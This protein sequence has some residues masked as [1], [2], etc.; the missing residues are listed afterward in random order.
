M[1]IYGAP[2][3]YGSSK[4]YGEDYSGLKFVLDVDWM[5]TGGFT[6]ESES[7]NIKALSVERGRKYL[8][9]ADGK[10]FAVAETGKLD[11]KL[12]NRTGKYDP[13]KTT[14]VLYPYVV[15]RRLFQLRAMFGYDEYF[16]ICGQTTNIQP[17]GGLSQEARLTGSDGWD[18]LRTAVTV[19][20]QEGQGSEVVIGVLLDAVGW[21]WGRDIG[22]GAST[23]TYWWCDQ[24]SANSALH[25]LAHAELGRL[26]IDNAG[27][28]TF[29][30]RHIIPAVT[31]TIRSSDIDKEAGYST[32]QPWDVVRNRVTIKAHPQVLQSQSILWEATEK[33]FVANGATKHLWIDY[34]YNNKNVPAKA[35]VTSPAKPADFTSNTLANGTG[36]DLTAGWTVTV[37]PFSKRAKVILTN[38]SGSHG[39]MTLLRVRGQ[40]I[41]STYSQSVTSEDAASQAAYDVLDLELDNP[42]LQNITEA[43]DFAD[44][45][46]SVLKDPKPYFDCWLLPNNGLQLNI[47]LNKRY[48][49]NIPE[50]GI[51]GLYNIA[52]FG[53]YWDIE[54]DGLSL[55]TRVLFEPVAD[56]ASPTAMV[57]PYQFE[58]DS[59]FAL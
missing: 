37:V 39:Y 50:L 41:T 27:V 1:P 22:S 4:K 21:Q 29:Q 33:T 16:L 52:W 58:V 46:V 10:G 42:W 34:Q 54:S 12:N 38:G 40:A 24:Q 31:A 5:G 43:Q 15:P 51:L 25:E 20:L 6:I 18:N 19:G 35:V 9:E 30:S 57:F 26:W 48:Q 7:E 11:V 56:S 59:D 44:Y 45:L 2:L 32:P 53:H 55:R 17:I 49:L 14:S 8:V 28:L 13:Y 47:G 3:N 36:T 23:L